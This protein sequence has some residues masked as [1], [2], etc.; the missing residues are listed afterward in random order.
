MHDKEYARLRPDGCYRIAV[1]GASHT[2]GSGVDRDA[3]FEA[4]LENDLNAPGQGCVEVLN[5]AVYGYSPIDQI[6]VLEG[7]V[8]EFEPNAVLYVGHPE[9]TRRVALSLAQEVLAHQPPPYDPLAEIVRQAGIDP[10]M[11]ERVAVQRATPF[12]DQILAFVHHRLVS[13]SRAQGIC[14]VFALLPMV[15][16]LPRAAVPSE[17]AIAKD[18][19]FTVFDLSDVYEGSDRNSLWIAEWDAHPNAAAHRLIGEKLYRLWTQR[20]AT[21]LEC[22]GPA[23]AALSPPAQ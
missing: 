4:I 14:P 20:A 13:Y 23:R 7:R 15:P 3:T 6:E 2:M 18:A 19:G 21:L 8:I 10:G 22:P 1:L 9:D 16:D 11:T 12:G 17:L 5:F